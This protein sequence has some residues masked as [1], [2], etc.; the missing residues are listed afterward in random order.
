MPKAASVDTAL[1]WTERLTAGGQRGS[2]APTF[3][4]SQYRWCR[5]A[6]GLVLGCVTLPKSSRL[7]AVTG[8]RHAL[9]GGPRGG[10]ERH[11]DIPS[12]VESTGGDGRLVRRCVAQV[13]GAEQEPVIWCLKMLSELVAQVAAVPLTAHSWVQ[14]QLHDDGAA[15]A[16]LHAGSS[17]D[18]ADPLPVEH[19]VEDRP[20]REEFV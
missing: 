17:G 11:D 20:G 7:L 19:D 15:K 12:D 2:G 6:G 4:V 9:P 13:D 1:A 8:R 5:R 14:Q 3:D 16:V 10:L 18:P